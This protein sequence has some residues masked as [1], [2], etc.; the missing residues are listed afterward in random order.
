MYLRS[1]LKNTYDR[2]LLEAT[3]DV[4]EETKRIISNLSLNIR[5]I[6]FNTEQDVGHEAAMHRLQQL[7]A[8]AGVEWANSIIGPLRDRLDSIL[9]QNEIWQFW[10]ASDFEYGSGYGIDK[11]GYDR[12]PSWCPNYKIYYYW[13]NALLT[14]IYKKSIEDGE[15]E[16][17]PSVR[18]GSE[19]LFQARYIFVNIKTV[20]RQLIHDPGV[21]DRVVS[22]LTHPMHVFMK[23][24][25]DLGS[26]GSLIYMNPILS[27]IEQYFRSDLSR[28]DG[29]LRN[30][31]D[32]FDHDETLLRIFYWYLLS[33]PHDAIANIYKRAQIG[34]WLW[35]RGYHSVLEDRDP[36]FCSQ[37]KQ[38]MALLLQR[39]DPQPP[40]KIHERTVN[41]FW[42]AQRLFSMDQ[43]NRITNLILSE[44]A[45]TIVFGNNPPDTIEVRNYNMD[46]RLFHNIPEDFAKFI[47][48]SVQGCK[49]EALYRCSC[50]PSLFYCSERCQKATH[51]EIR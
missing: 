35:T 22:E 31:E 3:N 50:S 47:S 25:S 30:V 46:P 8:K 13:M 6:P 36:L 32:F 24:A 40:E 33:L 12:L 43:S 2:L 9:S 51:K 1:V 7:T 45:D 19:P 17:D 41:Y 42:K 11:Y 18:R 38:S 4:A 44:Y 15:I 20:K 37:V 14:K 27:V 5:T 21:Y 49:Q 23:Y 39:V 29:Y 10:M 26:A 16:K 34:V 28:F 48:C